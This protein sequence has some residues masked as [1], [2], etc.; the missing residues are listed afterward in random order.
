MFITGWSVALTAG[1]FIVALLWPTPAAVLGWVALVLGLCLLDYLLAPRPELLQIKAS[2]PSAIRQGA[3]TQVTL[4][5]TNPSSRR[6]H[7]VARPLWPSS[8]QND[9]NHVALKLRPQQA[10]RL[11]FTLFPTRRGTTLAQGVTIRSTG[12]LNLAG[13]QKTLPLAT[14]VQVLPAFNSRVHLPGR[15]RRLQELEG[16]TALITRGAGTEFDSL[17]AYV[18]GD[19]VR[20]IDWRASARS[21]DI[22]VRT[23]RPERDQNL[24]IV[25]DTSRLSALRFGDEPRL[26]THLDAALLL[27]A[28]AAGAADR[29]S[30]LALDNQA[31]LR[32]QAPPRSEVLPTLARAFAPLEPSLLEFS[33]A[34]LH[35]E[36]TEMMPRH[37]TV[38]ILTAIESSGISTEIWPTLKEL[39]SLHTVILASAQDPDI[40]LLSTQR[41][42]E[43]DLF[44]AAAADRALLEEQALAAMISRLGI[45]LVQAPPQRLAPAL[46]DKYLQL[47]SG[48]K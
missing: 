47:K 30:V 24:L 15:L 36:I 16:R 41:N 34:N 45:A 19:D 37:S 3:S 35:R 5:L 31:R 4:T 43:S 17:R 8:A 7:L 6:F 28:L 32:L 21:S 14:R 12:L 22:M 18:H 1:A 48:H 9:P 10:T 20:D 23:W 29:I 13:R 26:D 38:V 44:T 2:Q 42:T 40:G 25:L 33:W 39:A 27:A 11:E 46:A